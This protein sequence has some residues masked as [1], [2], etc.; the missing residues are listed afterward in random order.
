MKRFAIP[1]NISFEVTPELIEKRDIMAAQMFLCPKRRNGQSLQQK[2]VQT[3]SG[4]FLEHALELQGAELNPKEFNVKDRDS[5]CWDA[6]W[7][8]LY[9][10]V[11]RCK[12]TDTRSWFSFSQQQ[13]K[14][15]LNNTDVLDL[16]IVGDYSW[17]GVVGSY[18]DVTWILIAPID[19]F[20]QNI[21]RS[22]FNQNM[23]YYN[24]KAEPRSVFLM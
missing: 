6:K 24:H 7:D 4:I 22:Q 5:Y 12:I 2:I 15:M 17:D 19:T 11:K 9:A 16:L 18:C 20:K 10:E 21:N 13:V 1:T 23:L 8:G 14:T 3:Q